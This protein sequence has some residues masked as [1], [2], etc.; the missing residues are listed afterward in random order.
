MPRKTLDEKIEAH[1]DGRERRR[2]AEEARY[3]ARLEKRID[4]AD[5]MIGELVRD[6]ET[7]LYVW[8]Q[9][10]RYR[11]GSRAELSDFLMRNNY[12]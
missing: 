3:L 2:M 7:V 4:D 10:G 8:P 9:G 1:L 11:E 12:A 6:G 5:S